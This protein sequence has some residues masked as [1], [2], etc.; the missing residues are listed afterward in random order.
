MKIIYVLILMCGLA[1][2]DPVIYE[3]FT[4]DDFISGQKYFSCYASN[5][6]SGTLW[7]FEKN[8]DLLSTNW[9]HWGSDYYV[10]NGPAYTIPYAMAG[11]PATNG[12]EF[13]R[14]RQVGTNYTFYQSF[15]ASGFSEF[16]S[17]AE[18]QRMESARANQPV[19]HSETIE[20]HWV[21][22]IEMP[23]YLYPPGY[24]H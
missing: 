20:R 4:Y 11:H 2:A 22:P 14:M 15:D 13:F 12:M 17:A 23:D 1:K 9:T 19:I 21:Y 10:G 7:V 8:N 5:L 16:D 6:D 3:T 18:A 24:L